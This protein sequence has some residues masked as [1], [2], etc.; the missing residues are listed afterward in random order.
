MT[1]LHILNAILWLF[2]AVLWFG[3][4]HVTS[5]TVVSLLAA[6]GSLLLAR[7]EARAEGGQDAAEGNEAV[8]P[9]SP[10]L[11]S[12]PATPS[13]DVGIANDFASLECVLQDA[14]EA[15]YAAAATI[16]RLTAELAE[17]HKRQ[18]HW[19]QA[20]RDA[21]TGG[22]I[23]KTELNEAQAECEEQARLLGMSGSREAKL[24]TEI[25]SL[26]HDN[27]RMIARESELVSESER[28]REVLMVAH[29]TICG[30]VEQQ[31]MPDEHWIKPLEAIDAAIDAARG[32]GK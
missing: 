29:D 14:N 16:T 31:A 19:Q 30:L 11:I 7:A 6:I 17:A 26:K 13:P 22:D 3:Y 18:T 15:A 24:L 27:A 25:D 21:C 10:G 5:M 1:I 32:E 4:A 23:L 20:Y 12:R 28:L 8:V 2:N 9:I